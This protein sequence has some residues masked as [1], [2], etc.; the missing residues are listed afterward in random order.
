MSTPPSTV[1][2]DISIMGDFLF[3]IKQFFQ[4]AAVDGSYR[5]KAPE[6]SPCTICRLPPALRR[7]PHVITSFEHA[8]R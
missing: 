8:L 1:V 2:E 3:Y 4:L 6:S 7:W 5:E